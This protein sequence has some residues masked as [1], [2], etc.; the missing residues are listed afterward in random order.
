MIEEEG[1]I[2]V[3]KVI[4]EKVIQENRK[5]KE[6]EKIQEVKV[7][8]IKNGKNK[9][10]ANQKV[11]VKE[12]GHRHMDQNLQKALKKNKN[13]KKI[14]KQNKNRNKFRKKNQMRVAR[15][16]LQRLS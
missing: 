13:R 1:A 12:R 7:V 10:K 4:Q 9:V 3:D 15:N 14:L 2:Q 6:V 8:E 11:L 5:D 16:I